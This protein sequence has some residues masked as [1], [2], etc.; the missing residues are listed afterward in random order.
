MT[1]RC[2]CAGLTLRGVRCKRMIATGTTHCYQHTNN[3][4]GDFVVV[5]Q[6]P[7]Q[8]VV[9]PVVVPVV[10]M[11]VVPVDPDAHAE[12][13]M[14]AKNGEEGW[15]T[16]ADVIRHPS[17][18]VYKYKWMFIDAIRS[19]DNYILTTTGT[20]HLP[21]E[22][23]RR[24][25]MFGFELFRLNKHLYEEQYGLQNLF[26][27]FMEKLL[28]AGPSMQMYRDRLRRDVDPVYREQMRI[29]E[30]TAKKLAAKRK[31]IEHIFTSSVLGPL[32]ALKIA[33][34]YTE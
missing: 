7:I 22:P 20:E 14:Y 3:S 34:S 1:L 25:F 8:P 29:I 32:I 18:K 6:P 13:V 12:M 2:Q 26:S 31:Y 28:Q 11:G 5:P 21:A 33:D 15:P 19:F 23:S 27:V 4:V 9:V 17:F 16:M 24:I 10:E 30:E